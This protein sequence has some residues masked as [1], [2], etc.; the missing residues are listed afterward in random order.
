MMLILVECFYFHKTKKLSERKSRCEYSCLADDWLSMMAR[1]VVE[2]FK[3]DNV[4]DV[5]SYL[6]CC[7][8][9]KHFTPFR[10]GSPYWVEF[11]LTDVTL[12]VEYANLVYA[13]H[14]H[15]HHHHHHDHHYQVEHRQGAH[16]RS[17]LS[18]PLIL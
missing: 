15:H 10:C 4:K 12:A 7:I 16:D 3:R 17:Q 13:C 11:D 14:H 1:H 2:P 5:C 6:Y 8:V 9:E 18:V